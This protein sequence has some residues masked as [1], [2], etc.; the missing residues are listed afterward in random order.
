MANCNSNG[1][2][3]YCHIK[4][5]GGGTV[6]CVCVRQCKECFQTAHY[7]DTRSRWHQSEG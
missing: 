4:R 5:E 1:M 2:G 3:Q 7:S 6:K